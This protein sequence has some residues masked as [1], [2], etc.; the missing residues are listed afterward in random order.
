MDKRIIKAI[1]L[2]FDLGIG[3]DDPG[4]YKWLDNHKAIEC[5]DSVAFLKYS[6][7]T[8]KDDDII[9]DVKKDIESCVKLRAGDRIYIIRRDSTS[10][11]ISVKGA[12]LTG[13]RKASPWEGYGDNKPATSESGE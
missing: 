7:E 12:F 11:P 1:W 4:L 2:S 6:V 13:K 10:K 3:G 8:D 5:G 9:A